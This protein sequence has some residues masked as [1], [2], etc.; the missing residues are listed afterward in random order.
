MEQQ[1]ERHYLKFKLWVP[2]AEDAT[3]TVV[4]H[5]RAVNGLRF[6]E[7]HDELYWNLTGDEWDVPIEAVTARIDLPPAASGVRAIAFNGAYGSTA[8]ESDVAIEG[9]TVRVTMP[10]PLG[11][12]EGRDRRRGL[13]QGGG[14]GADGHRQG[15]T[16]S[17]RT[18][19]PSPSRSPSSSPCSSSGAGSGATPRSGRSRRSTSRRPG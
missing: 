16:A 7:D 12:H 13:G 8:Q 1:R 6:F 4:F 18:T 2:G 10:H 14:R 17:W 3:R 19:G 11:F 15:G 9:H 5:Y